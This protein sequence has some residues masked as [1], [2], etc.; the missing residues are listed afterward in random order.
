MLFWST[1]GFPVQPREEQAQALGTRLQQAF[2]D[3]FF[4]KVEDEGEHLVQ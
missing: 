1:C 2:P 4:D 3:E